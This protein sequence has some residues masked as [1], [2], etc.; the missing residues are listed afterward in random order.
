[1]SDKSDSHKYL[2][3]RENCPVRRRQ[4]T[5]MAS[6]LKASPGK[7]RK[8]KAIVYATIANSVA[9]VPTG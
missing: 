1:E 9:E 4:K 8:E 2:P 5:P 7:S 6:L 3:C